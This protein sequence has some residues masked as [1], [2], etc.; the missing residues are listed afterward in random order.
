MA[1]LFRNGPV[2]SLN[3]SDVREARI[4]SLTSFVTVDATRDAFI[5]AALFSTNIPLTETNESMQGLQAKQVC[6]VSSQPRV[7]KRLPA[8]IPV[9]P[10]THLAAVFCF[11]QTNETNA[12]G[13]YQILCAGGGWGQHCFGCSSWWSSHSFFC[14]LL[15]SS[16]G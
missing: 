11:F 12:E 15:L 2:F 13:H 9:C 16:Q 7:V 8:E 4:P 6:I 1:V 3:I 14:F 10:E 5:F